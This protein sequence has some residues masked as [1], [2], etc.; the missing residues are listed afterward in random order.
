MTTRQ[1]KQGGLAPSVGRSSPPPAGAVQEARET[2]G[3]DNVFVP[4][5]G[6]GTGGDTAP[7]KAASS[8]APK[9][10]PTPKP[11]PPESP[12][13]N[14]PGFVPEP[15]PASPPPPARRAPPPD[16]RVAPS[17]PNVDRNE[18]VSELL[19]DVTSRDNPALR[20]ARERGRRQAASRG[21]LN[22]SLAAQSGEAAFLDRAVPLA[23]QQGQIN[24]ARNLSDQEFRQQQALTQQGLTGDALLQESQIA[25]QRRQ[26]QRDIAAQER[27]QGQ[28]LEFQ[29]TSQQR[30]IAA[31]ERLQLQELDVQRDLAFVDRE[32]REI[33]TNIQN[34][35][36]ERIAQLNQNSFD[37]EKA[38]STAAAFQN[39]FTEGF[40]T[41]GQNEN[42]P[43][44]VRD[45]LLESLAV[46]RDSNLNLVEQL[47]NVDL[48][49][50]TPTPRTAPPPQGEDGG[51]GQGGSGG[52]QAVPQRPRPDP[53]GR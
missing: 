30:D 47:F 41:I 46:Q 49:F 10:T 40:R 36:R 11:T 37:R 21:L 7:A 25:A 16:Q 44:D 19:A 15:A 34:E 39:S 33:I 9:P 27:L 1:R 18:N 3:A 51:S 5:A 29:D 17:A 45:R 20:Q 12:I 50:A 52:Q 23:Q 43:A 31:Q 26:Q 35:S 42:L 48:D 6:G 32:T 24:S 28:E 8:P 4:G 38:A 14:I 22:S 13:Q 2:F 53:G